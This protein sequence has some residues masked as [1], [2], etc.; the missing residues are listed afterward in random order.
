MRT[1]AK[2]SNLKTVR[3]VCVIP[4]LVICAALSAQKQAPPGF[5]QV[6]YQI[7]IGTRAGQLRY[8]KEQF[9]VRP[10]SK[11]ALTLVN[12]DGMQ[13][14]LLILRPGKDITQKVG[15]LAMRM[16]ASAADKHFVPDTP[17]VLFHTVAILPGKSDTIWFVAP[18]KRGAYPYVCTL[19]GHMFTMRG[20]MHVGDAPSSAGV[21]SVLDDVRYRLYLGSWKKLPVFSEL[22]P[23]REGV[24]KG[25]LFDLGALKKRDHFGVEFFGKLKI[26]KPG[27]YKFFL[28]SD[29]GSRLFVDDKQVAEY[30]G[31]HGLAGPKVGK[32]D[33]SEG[34]HQIKVEFFQGGGG[35]GLQLACKG[36][37]VPRL[38]LATKPKPRGQKGIPIMVMHK[39]VIS[40]VH[41]EG[42][43]A[44]SIAVGLPHGMN[45]CFDAGSC[46]VLFGWAGAYLDVGPD[47]SGR[48][49]QPCKILGNRF[50]TGNIGFPLRQADGT[51][52]P[53]K[54][55]GY[56]K[57][58]SPE[59][60]FDWGGRDV[61]WRIGPAGHGVGLRYEFLI[62]G[63]VGSVQFHLGEDAMMTAP[64]GSIEAGV[65]T[66]PAGSRDRFELSIQPRME[67]S[68]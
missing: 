49:G 43:S 11:V 50:P 16:G 24:L 46:A 27:R 19:P 48:G 28:N 63:G 17:D 34:Q 57:G 64:L 33:L 35:L 56:R 39:P 22:K 55:K 18:S 42:G 3:A 2:V 25:G 36:P 37:G 14:N 61:R 23:E 31:L 5:E 6:D 60:Q 7:R 45:F 9:V 67:K 15:M 62:S 65:L 13:H 4:C 30:D 40:R 1:V 26:E 54:F 47:R 41:L 20:V 59:F 68:K 66:I 38:E 51:K 12:A 52:L 21:E 29:D 44:R 10:G 8:D 32:I 58:A 53:V